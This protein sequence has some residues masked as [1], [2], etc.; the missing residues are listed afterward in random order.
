[1][2]L[3]ILFLVP[4]PILFA[5]EM[6]PVFSVWHIWRPA[7]QDPLLLGVRPN[8]DLEMCPSFPARAAAAFLTPS[9]KRFYSPRSSPT[10]LSLSHLP[11]LRQTLRDGLDLLP[12]RRPR[13]H[14]GMPLGGLPLHALRRPL[15]RPPRPANLQGAAG[16]GVLR[17]NVAAAAAQRGGRGEADFAAEH[18]VPELLRSLSGYP[19][20]HLSRTLTI[21]PSMK[22]LSVFSVWVRTAPA[23]AY[24]YLT[25]IL[26]AIS[27][28]ACSAW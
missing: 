13:R 28:V 15:R 1:M 4:P 24:L 21:V 25:L 18:G 6:Q 23:R 26:R 22:L 3:T 8:M 5:Q 20:S 14:R 2:W 7:E 16:A 11:C 9:P 12:R 10:R 27:S 17:G 19:L